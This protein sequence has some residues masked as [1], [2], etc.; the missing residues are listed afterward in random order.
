QA[1]EAAAEPA[2][3]AAVRVVHPRLGVVLD[4]GGGALAQLVPAFRLGLGGPLADGSAWWSW[5]TLADL[6]RVLAFVLER[7]DLAGPVNAV[8]PAPVRQRELAHALGRALGRPSWLPAPAFALRLL[9]GRE[10]ADA[11]LFASQRAE[12]EA[13]VRAGFGFADP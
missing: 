1:W 12:P 3:A 6:V 13:L 9:L 5:I 2:R 4:P 10:R 11:M 7:G 8:G